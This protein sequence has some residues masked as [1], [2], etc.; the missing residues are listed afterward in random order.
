MHPGLSPFL[1]DVARRAWGYFRDTA[2][3]VTGLIPDRARADGSGVGS[4][5]SMA[6]TGFGLTSWAIGAQRGWMSRQE[7][8]RRTRKTLDVLL[9]GTPHHAGCFYHFVDAAQGQRAWQCEVSTID[10]AL[11]LA[12]VL[13]VRSAFSDDPALT[14]ACDQLAQRI[15]WPVFL[16][17]AGVLSH[18]WKPESGALPWS[19]SHFSEHILLT[20]LAIG[21]P[22]H[23]VPAETWTRWQ[24]SPW[25]DFGGYRFLHHPPLFVHQFPHAW[26]DF[27]GLRDG[28]IDYWQNSVD[29]TQAHRL[30]C[31]TLRE[32]FSSWSETDWGIT[33]SDGINGYTDWGG[34]PVD[35]T[36]GRDPR[37]DG[38][39]VP[40][41]A[42]GSL[43]FTPHESERTLEQF[44]L[45]YGSQLYGR[46]GFADAFNPETNWIA[47]DCLGIDQGITLL[48]IENLRDGLVWKL[49]MASSEARSALQRSGLAP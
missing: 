19:W 1:Q 41:A 8:I 29:A 47:P 48:M 6:A 18:G 24:R 5:A 31:Q 28:T 35:P 30:W 45:R 38:T 37:I 12:G 14:R 22:T 15:D 2:H 32:E 16:T 43:C 44:Q 36:L 11:L 3:P 4:V 13:T 40:C 27:R 21:S 17:S 49:F 9:H 23:P 20:L 34:P 33:S 25:M 39:L 46:Y 26:F 42:A 7:C 10:T